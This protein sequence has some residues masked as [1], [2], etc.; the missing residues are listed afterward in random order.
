MDPA[1][2]L[3]AR[4]LGLDSGRA[5]LD[6]DLVSLCLGFPMAGAVGSS[7]LASGFLDSEG[8]GWMC[9]AEWRR[10]G[11]GGSMS[12]SRGWAVGICVRRSPQCGASHRVQPR[13][14]E[15]VPCG[16]RTLGSWLTRRGRR[17]PRISPKSQPESC[18]PEGLGKGCVCVCVSCAF[19]ALLG[20]GRLYGGIES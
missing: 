19:I 18:D 8:T 14:L 5:L 16:L 13:P 10:A 1:C 20:E 3:S 6:S 11:S 17:G 4:L 2:G 15:G 7:V 9:R 12:S